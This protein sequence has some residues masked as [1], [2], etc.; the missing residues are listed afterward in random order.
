MRK[1]IWV[2]VMLG[3]CGTDPA[4]LPAG[5]V[6]KQTSDCKTGLMCLDVAQ[7]NGSA[8]TVVDQACSTTCTGDGDCAPLGT[9][10]KCFAGCG[11]A[12]FCGETP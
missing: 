7:F 6:C 8:C 2:V 9:K 5:A 10:F 11:S 4:P 12:K 1:A 3:A